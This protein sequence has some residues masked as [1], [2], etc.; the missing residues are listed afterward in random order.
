MAHKFWGNIWGERK[1]HRKDVEWLK[2]FIGDF[3]YKEEQEEVEIT[4]RFLVEKF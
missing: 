2:N 4:P 3:E 1:E